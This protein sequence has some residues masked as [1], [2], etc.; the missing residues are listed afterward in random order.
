MSYEQR[1][2]FFIVGNE[3]LQRETGH[4]MGGS[5][6]EPAT[7]VDLGVSIMEFYADTEVHKSCGM[8]L[9]G[10]EAHQHLAGVLHLDDG[11][12][13]SIVWYGKCVFEGVAKT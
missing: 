8:C 6:S 10:V 7:C 13:L 11:L 4:P 5:F 3:I 1:D 12:L 2:N 9:P